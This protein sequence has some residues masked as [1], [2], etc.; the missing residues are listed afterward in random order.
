MARLSQGLVAGMMSP[1]Y[2]GKLGE[3]VSGGF[4]DIQDAYQARNE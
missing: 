1:S 4:Q 3:A 2:A